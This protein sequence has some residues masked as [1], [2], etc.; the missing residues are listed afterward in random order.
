MV[1]KS[2]E[3]YTK[4]CKPV[5]H[6]FMQHESIVSRVTQPA[7]I[8]PDIW[9]GPITIWAKNNSPTVHAK[10]PWLVILS[11]IIVSSN[12]IFTLFLHVSTCFTTACVIA[13]ASAFRWTF[14][15]VIYCFPSLRLCNFS[16]NRQARWTMSVVFH[17]TLIGTTQQER[18]VAGLAG[19]LA[20]TSHLPISWGTLCPC[21]SL[22]NKAY[23]IKPPKACFT[24]QMDPANNDDVYS[25]AAE[26]K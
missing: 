12:N 5:N 17:V 24:L 21:W 15:H 9:W 23:R 8:K 2:T 22:Q 3:S 10:I 4:S 16:C 7:W 20:W 14:F 6:F 19:S 25:Q 11:Q 1:P 13:L 18:V 26:S